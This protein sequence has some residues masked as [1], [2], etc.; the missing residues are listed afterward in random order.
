M[1][2]DNL[3]RVG[4]KPI[5]N[6]IVACVTLFNSHM[7]EVVLR[8]RGRAIP[9]AVDTVLMLRK[10]FLK[11]VFVKSIQIG[12]DDIPNSEGKKLT[13]STMEITLSKGNSA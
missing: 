7:D 12:S 8:A 3:I 10:A 2:Q 11:D 13:I 1:N 6:Y 4:S 5:M 9:T